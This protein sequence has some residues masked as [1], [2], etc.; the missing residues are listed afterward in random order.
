MQCHDP[1]RQDPD[2]RGRSELHLPASRRFEAG[3]IGNWAQGVFLPREIFAELLK[4]L[5][6]EWEDAGC[7]PSAAS[8]AGAVALAAY[9]G[10]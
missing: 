5:M 4:S 2:R 8:T 6:A 3:V 9:R 7:A 10:K 1:G